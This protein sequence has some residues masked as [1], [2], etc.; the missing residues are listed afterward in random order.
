MRCGMHVRIV[1]TRC[2]N[3][4]ALKI[5]ECKEE[6]LDAHIARKKLKKCRQRRLT[7]LQP[8]IDRA[9][10]DAEDCGGSAHGATGI[11]EHAL[12]SLSLDLL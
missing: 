7:K 1:A 11:I 5:A 6:P 3:S 10:V 4:A 9:S 12:H 2:R 8:A